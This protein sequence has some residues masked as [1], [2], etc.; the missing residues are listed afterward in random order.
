MCHLKLENLYVFVRQMLSGWRQDDDRKKQEKNSELIQ[1]LNDRMENNKYNT[2]TG[3][4]NTRE[5]PCTKFK[6]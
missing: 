5:Y 6:W 4:T 3:K 1:L 2:K